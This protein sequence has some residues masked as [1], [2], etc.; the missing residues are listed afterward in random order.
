MPNTA[1]TADKISMG[2]I[3]GMPS[4][5]IEAAWPPPE[6]SPSFS[7]FVYRCW[8]WAGSEEKQWRQ[9]HLLCFLTAP[10]DDLGFIY[11]C[12]AETP[13]A[14]LPSAKAHSS[15]SATYQRVVP[16]F[17]PCQMT[18]SSPCVCFSLHSSCCFLASSRSKCATLA[19]S[20]SR[21]PALVIICG[22]A[23]P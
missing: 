15:G 21:P 9:W 22:F 17:S 4:I 5:S 2:W 18:P 12:M 14:D 13:G 3:R 11:R 23:P 8:M 20:S 1:D 6:G 10:M 7:V 19:A 16:I